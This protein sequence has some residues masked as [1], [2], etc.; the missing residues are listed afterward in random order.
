MLSALSWTPPLSVLCWTPS[1][2]YCQFCFAFVL[3][4][5]FWTQPHT[6]CRF[7]LTIS[8]VPVLFCHTHIL[9]VLSWT[10]PCTY[11][12]FYL[13]TKSA[14][15]IFPLIVILPV[16]SRHTHT[17]N[18]ILDSATFILPVLSCHNI[19]PIP[20]FYSLI[21]PVVSWTQPR[22]ITYC[23]FYLATT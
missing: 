8:L 5:I 21:L 1:L 15:S 18:S 2:T 17:A 23:Q 22:T 9:P 13:I 7:Y 12:R 20:S 10:Q 6:Y 4:V 14:S 3:K 19:V 16:L 11:C